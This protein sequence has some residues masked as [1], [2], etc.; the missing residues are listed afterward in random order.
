MGIDTQGMTLPLDPN[1]KGRPLDEQQ[2][3]LKLAVIN[4]LE[5]IGSRFIYTLDFNKF[6]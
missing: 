3:N 2:S 4:A 5:K 6:N 1:F